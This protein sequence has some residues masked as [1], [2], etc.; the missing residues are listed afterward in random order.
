MAQSGYTPLLSYGSTTAT[1][2]PLAAN[3]TTSASGVELA[4]NAADGKLFYKDTGGVVQVLAS[5]SGNVNV[6]SFQTSLGGL[7]PSTATTGI[8]TLAG[9][10]NTSSGGTG[11]TSYTA[12]DLSY[13]AAGTLLSKLGIGTAGQILT[14][15]SGATAPQ[16]S[17]L[18]GVAVTTFSAG[19]TGLTPNSATTG[20]V[21]LSGTLATTNGG[22]GLTSFTANGVVY[23]SST[24]ALATGSGITYNGTTFSTSNDASIHGL[25]V[26]QGGGSVSGSTV[27]GYQAGTSNV[28]G[29]I[30]AFGYQA[31][32]NNN[33]SSGLNLGV[34]YQAG[35]SITTGT[36][37]VAVGSYHSLYNT[38]TGSANVA[39]GREA[40]QANTTASNN[41]AVGY[42]AGYST[43]TGA[44]N[45]FLGYQAGY[46]FTVGSTATYGSNVC[47]GA[48]SGYSLTSGIS[49]TLIGDQAGYGL[50][51]GSANTFVGGGL[52]GT[53]G[54]SG[55]LITTGSKNSILGN[56]N[57]N[58]GGLDI[59]TASNYIVLSDGDGNPRGIFDGS[60]N[61][62][63]GTTTL[64]YS[65][66]SGF[67]FGVQSASYQTIGHASGSASGSTYVY[68]DYNGATIG[69]I[70][71]SGTT[72]VLYN[73]TSDRRLKTNIVDA[74]PASA[75][76]DAI[77]VRQYNWKSDGSHQRYGFV[78]QELVTVAPEAVHQPDDP[79][80]M[81]AVDYSKLVPML[82]KEIQ[83]LRK[84]LAA[85][86]I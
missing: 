6:A 74:A 45:V 35:Y 26:G 69:S 37:N 15:N 85:A 48:S 80:E 68:F 62:L 28:T 27:V 43:T 86:G 44:R 42:H 18:S 51:T 54:A 83:S 52:Y 65:S 50:T 70:T 66:Q 57:G 67:T 24:S 79:E 14:V 46:T 73:L 13:Y 81:M 41:T 25:T 59:R 11:L 61:L 9:T 77:Q 47:L 17:T 76:I 21:T 78:A 22:T 36:D 23:A 32:Y 71:Q 12:G 49:N 33:T 40:L 38:T 10:L 75:L 60:G 30:T 16:W 53:T 64:G 3:L 39:I 5:K 63:V 2:V 34:G 8:V 1:N 19:T 20:A 56:Y 55:S 31:L 7:T 72:A 84:R 82:V 4:V 29:A 58:Q